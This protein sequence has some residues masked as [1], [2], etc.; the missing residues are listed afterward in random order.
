[1]SKFEFTD[2]VWDLRVSPQLIHHAEQLSQYWGHLVV[3]V[4]S[5]YLVYGI[6]VGVHRLYL[7]PL[8]RAGIPGPKLAALTFFYE[9]YYEAWLGGQMF[10]HVRELH[11]KYGPVVRITP[12]EVHFDD[13]EVIDYVFPTAGRKTDKPSWLHTKTGTPE[14]IFS[15]IH[16]D[17]HRQ[18]RNAVSSFFSPASV[19]RLEHVL[20]DNLHKVLARLDAHGRSEEVI[21]IHY[22]FKALAS[23]LITFYSFDQCHNLLDAPDY[24]KKDF[25]AT[26]SLFL[27]THTGKVVPWLMTVFTRAPVWIVKILFPGLIAMRERREWWTNAVREIR[28]SPDPQRIKRTV[29]EGILSS[30]LPD[31]DKTDIRMAGEAQ[32]VVLG[33]EGTTAWTM[34]AAL[35]HILADPLV[36]KKLKAELTTLPHTADGIPPLTEVENLPY[37][38]AV[39]QESIRVHPGVMSRQMR[40]S[41]EVPIIYNDKRKGK[42]YSVPP[43]TVYSM[44]PVDVHMNPDYHEDPYEFRPERWLENPSLGKYFLGFGKGS[45]NCLGM[46]LAKRELA[47]TLATIF[48]KYDLYRGQDG[49]TMELYHTERARDI[50]AH[51]DF[52]SPF[53]APGSLGLRVKI[54]A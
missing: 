12:D 48:T 18:R 45:R 36:C 41:P 14:S 40:V 38:G 25:D 21:Q 15:T 7:S 22:M 54:R 9:A 20:N 13:P 51:S 30:K 2:S 46:A 1:M 47:L 24:G 11:K 33:G 23:D 4:L 3:S 35:Y 39:I 50:D 8:G 42:T 53:P 10:Q 34:H 32:L 28:A 31:S 17:Q 49:P 19:H 6:A 27:M 37:L 16:H 43:G 26:D 44:S 5:A 29:F 52:I